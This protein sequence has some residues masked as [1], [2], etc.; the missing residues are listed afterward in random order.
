MPSKH[1]PSHGFDAVI[2]D[3]SELLILGS[4]PSVKSRENAFYY[5]HPQNRFWSVLQA[6]YEDDNFLSHDITIK[7]R[8][9]K[10]HHITLYDVIESCD[11]IGSKDSSITN[12]TPVNITALIKGTSITK[13][14]LNGNKAGSLFNTYNPA[15]RP[16]ATTVPSTSS[17]NA[18]YGLERLVK[19]WK[20]AINIKPCLK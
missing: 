20:T 4:F 7:I 9:L 16:L 8:A 13:V 18:Q 15:L 17:A 12:V 6:I 14:L 5:M 19:T 3:Q 1:I 11:I 10:E 2:D